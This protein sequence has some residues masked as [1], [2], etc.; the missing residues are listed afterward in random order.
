M[1]DI[2][3]N[4]ANTDQKPDEKVEAAEQA[5]PAP[6]AE[7]E[8]T[9]EA[10]APAADRPV[11]TETREHRERP[12]RPRGRRGGYDSSERGDKEPGSSDQGPRMPRFKK[13]VCI[14]CQ[15]KNASVDYKRPDIL[16]RFITD[17]GKILPRRVTGTCAKHQR[18]V[19]KEIKRART[20]ALLPFVEK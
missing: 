11:R 20:I 10:A 13:K 7:P 3:N 6:A 15:D 2:I 16:E 12:D 8:K 17:R 14:F 9:A 1:S 4:E 5:Q 18:I 19:A